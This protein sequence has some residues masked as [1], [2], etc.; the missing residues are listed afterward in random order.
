MIIHRRLLP[1]LALSVLLA[2]CGSSS[3]GDLA[4]GARP[5]SDRLVDL[6]AKPPLVNALDIDPASGDFL[7]TTNRGFFRIGA[8][9]Q[10]VTQIKGTISA[11]GK[12]DTVGTFL[13]IET[14]GENRLI[15]SGHPDNQDTLP[16]FLGF[17]ESTDSGKT[18]KVLARLGDADLHKIVTLHDKIYAF[19]A[20][21]GAILISSDNGKTFE[22]RF[23]PR[24]LVIDFVVD[25]QDEKYL[26]AATEDQLFKTEDAG[27]RWRPV[28]S[29]EGIRLEWTATGVFRADK[30]GTINLSTDRGATFTPVG[31]VDGEPY[32]FKATEDPD[33]LFLALSDGT[34]LETTDA[35]KTWKPVFTP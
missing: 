32:K 25:P 34:I 3:S 27:E 10:K 33:K 30:D 22:E 29:G 19:D 18:W 5:P 17:I 16:Q 35:G 23:T 2:G 1:L 28:T 12:T 26:L 4:P 15:G 20:V 6:D 21:L 8:K 11:E 9:D 7:L 13:E 14:E 31:K 24:G